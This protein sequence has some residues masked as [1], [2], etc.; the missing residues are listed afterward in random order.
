M[1]DNSSRRFFVAVG[2]RIFV[3]MFYEYSLEL[4]TLLQLLVR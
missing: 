2:K 3:V 1:I 4:Q